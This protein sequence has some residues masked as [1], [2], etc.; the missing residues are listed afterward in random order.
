LGTAAQSYYGV[1]RDLKDNR[2]PKPPSAEEIE[3][4]RNEYVDKYMVK[5]KDALTLDDLQ[6][7][8]IKNELI[9][10]SKSIDIVMKKEEDSQEDKSKE[11]RA[12]MDKTEATI[13]SY[14]NKEQKEKYLLFRANLN[15]K[16]D[17]DKDKKK[18]KENKKKKEDIPTFAE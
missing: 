6:V 11:V 15:K 12:L 8:A 7:I 13:N 2:A 4:S 3:K 5:L 18:E 17:K 9:T 14:L 16:K 10:N 1:N